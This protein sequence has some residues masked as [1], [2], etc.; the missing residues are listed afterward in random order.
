MSI[1]EHIGKLMEE[2]VTA[3]VPVEIYSEALA[4]FMK[5][6]DEH[7]I[8]NGSYRYLKGNDYYFAMQRRYDFCMNKARQH[9]KGEVAR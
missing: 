4:V 3:K 7:K 6:Y 8:R 9:Y 5:S 2:M 1:N